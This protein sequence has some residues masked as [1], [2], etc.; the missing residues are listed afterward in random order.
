MSETGNQCAHLLVC[1][2]DTMGVPHFCSC[3]TIQNCTMGVLATGI[4]T[5]NTHTHTPHTHHTHTHT[6]HTHTHTPTHTRLH[7]AT[8]QTGHDMHAGL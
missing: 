1:D 7:A 4:N 5:H 2:S 3:M 6:T 8:I